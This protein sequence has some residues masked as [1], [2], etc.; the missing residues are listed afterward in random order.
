MQFVKMH[1]AGNDYIFLDCLAHPRPDSPEQLAMLLSDRHRGI[2]SDGL[3]LIE[4][5]D[6]AAARMSMWNADG[7][8]GE[9][10]G[11]GLRCLASYLFQQGHCRETRFTVA[12]AAGPRNI[13]LHVSGEAV[14][15]VAIDMG[16]PVLTGEKIPTTLPGI[17]PLDVPLP[18]FD[19]ERPVSCVSMGNP[20]CILFVDALSEEEVRRVGPAIEWH[21]AFPARTN[22][23]FARVVS[24]EEIEI[25]VWERGSGMTQAC[26]TGACATVVA[27]ALTGRTGRSV[28][29]RLPGGELN[30]EWTEAGSVLLTGPAEI[31]FTG[32]WRGPQPA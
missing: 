22:V 14:L 19:G 15:S 32:T 6:S 11:N 7:T 5:D 29:C 13:E 4:P 20:H 3:I 1:G 27:A 18:L 23:E 10:C 9:M 12:T 21:P 25:L 28:L 2:G 8:P 24:P 30:V 16:R 31:S 26:G 17:P